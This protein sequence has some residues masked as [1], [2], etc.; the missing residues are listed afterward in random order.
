MFRF[1][2]LLTALLFVPCWAAADVPKLVVMISIDQ[3]PYEYLER[4]RPGFSPEGAFLRLCDQGANFTNCH[5]GHAFTKTGPGHSV[6]LTGTFPTRN[7]IIENDWY[8]PQAKGG[9]PGRMYCVDDADVQIVGGPGKDIGKSPKNLL[10]T[11][12]GDTLKLVRPESRVF[13]VALKDRAGILM[14]GH[15]ADG[16]YWLDAG[17]WVTSTYYRSDLPPYL[18]SLNESRAIGAYAGQTWDLLYPKDRYT[19]Y[20][21]DDAE[22]EGK[23]PGSGRAFPHTM[24]EADDKLYT[25]AMTTSPFGTE[26]TLAAA[27]ALIAAEELGRRAGTDVLAVNLSSNDY[28]GHMFGPHSLEVQDITWRTDRMLGE[29]AAFIDK[30]LAGAPWVM[31]LSS[32]HGVAP[33]PEYAE[34]KKIPAGRDALNLKELKKR[35]ETVLG[36][37]LI[38]Q[39]EENQVYLSADLDDESRRVTARAVRDELLKEPLIVAA[40]T[41]EELVQGEATVGL[42]QQFQRT[43]NAL[44][45]GDVLY[46]LAPY[47]I[48]GKTPATHGSPWEYDSHV[49]LLLWGHGIRGGRY[50]RSVTPAAIAPTFA[51]IL[52]I[53]P[54]AAASVDALDEALAP[55]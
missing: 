37:P 18:R 1:V 13:A 14:A 34:S 54:P 3:F 40:F 19:L 9:K 23:L 48:T 36:E 45:S 47:H 24:P 8:D 27:K 29:F 49:P 32:D 43:F 31:A 12:L 22:F 50:S 21:P 17:N 6:F 33:V 42:A 20:Y 26:Y 16:V 35:I 38:A 4:L 5:H 41:R 25:T 44:R 53:D 52:G 30:H 11:T 10:V 2:C 28:V 7:G 15:A 51:K 46:A 55:R 39:L